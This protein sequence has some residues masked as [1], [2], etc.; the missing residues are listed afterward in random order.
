[1]N[2][3]CVT[4]RNWFW[5][6]P[7]ATRRQWV[8]TV[9]PVSGLLQCLFSFLRFAMSHVKCTAVNGF[10][11]V[12]SFNPVF[13]RFSN[14]DLEVYLHVS[15]Y[16]FDYLGLLRMCLKG[17]DQ[18]SQLKGPRLM[19][20]FSKVPPCATVRNQAWKTAGQMATVDIGYQ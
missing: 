2:L 19:L 9:S 3:P 12:I 18:F 10:M 14:H 11:H 17:D 15:T 7:S 8:D 4:A 20:G 6:P 5:C 1:M 16:I 13:A